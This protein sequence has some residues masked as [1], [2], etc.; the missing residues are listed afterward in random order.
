MWGHE[1]ETLATVAHYGFGTLAGAIY[2][3]LVPRGARPAAGALYASAIW[4]VSYQHILPRLRLM[5]PPR[6]DDTSRQVVLAVDHV[7]YG[8]VLDACLE[9]LERRG[10]LRRRT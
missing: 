10:P 8:V 3:A 6:R 4:A 9:G 2:A 7:I 5:P 1:T